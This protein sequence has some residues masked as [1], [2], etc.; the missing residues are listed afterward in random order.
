MIFAGAHNDDNYYHEILDAI[1]NKSLADKVTI[2]PMLT[3]DELV[4][5]YQEADICFFSSYQEIGFSSTPLEAMAC[6]CIVISY[7][8]EGSDEIIDNGEN[9]FLVPA[10]GL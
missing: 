8:N 2:Q 9:G 5:H 4:R 3:Q 6:G 7:G 1:Q 10:R